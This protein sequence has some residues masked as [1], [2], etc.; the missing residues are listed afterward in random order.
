MNPHDHPHDHTEDSHTVAVLDAVRNC[1]DDVVMHTPADRIVSAGRARVR[2]RLFGVTTGVTAIGVLALG[3]PALSGG[4]GAGSG[5]AAEVHVRTVAYSVDSN[6]DGTVRVTWSKQRYFEDHAGLQRALRQAGFPV[7]IKEGEF[8][9]GPQDETALGDGGVG[10]GVMAEVMRGQRGAD[11]EV[12]FVFDPAAM[13][14]GKQLFIG[15][16]SPAQRAA[17]GGRL[18]S[19]ERLVPADGPLTCSTRIPVVPPDRPDPAGHPDR[20]PA[21]P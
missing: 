11:D 9:T 15:Y 19:V 17:T 12:T 10:P 18:G 20:K 3:V 4:A 16:L 1:M 13:P 21:T 5:G 7:L 2:R 14:A 6:A 8:C